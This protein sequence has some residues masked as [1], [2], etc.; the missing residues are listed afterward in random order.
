MYDR[1]ALAGAITRPVVSVPDVMCT[2]VSS[3]IGGSGIA[4]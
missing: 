3:G 1:G 2:L 4:R